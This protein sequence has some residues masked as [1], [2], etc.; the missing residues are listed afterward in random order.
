MRDTFFYES[1]YEFISQSSE[2]IKK[3]VLRQ[4]LSS[5]YFTIAVDATPHSLLNEQTAFLLRYVL[6]T[7]EQL[8][9][10]KRVLKFVNCTKKQG[11]K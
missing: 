7:V 6:Q 8:L 3:H 1:Q 11:R 9:V 10:D 2:L 4:R 5:Y